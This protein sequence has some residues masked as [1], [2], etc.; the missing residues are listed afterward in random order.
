MASGVRECVSG[1]LERLDVRSLPRIRTHETK[2][3]D[4]YF[5]DQGKGKIT[6][7]MK[8]EEDFFFKGA[9]AIEKP[10]VRLALAVVGKWIYS[11]ADRRKK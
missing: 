7:A 2:E 10:V 1:S 6:C 9:T 3:S 8:E 11:S 5:F 4:P